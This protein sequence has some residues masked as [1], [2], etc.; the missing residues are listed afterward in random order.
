[1]DGPVVSLLTTHGRVD[2]VVPR[3]S[4]RNVDYPTVVVNPVDAQA[5][6]FCMS[7]AMFLFFVSPQRFLSLQ[8]LLKSVPELDGVPR[9]I[10]DVERNNNV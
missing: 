10:D 2:V 8:V 9:T 5:W 7:L 4:M 6:S 3:L 1:M